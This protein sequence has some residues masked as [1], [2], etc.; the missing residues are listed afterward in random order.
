MLDLWLRAHLG[1]HTSRLRSAAKSFKLEPRCLVV[2]AHRNAGAKRISLTNSRSYSQDQK[3][4]IEGQLEPLFP[5]RYFYSRESRTMGRREDQ[6]IFVRDSCM[7]HLCVG[8]TTRQRNFQTSQIP[9]DI[10]IRRFTCEGQLIK[11]WW[12]NDIHGFPS[13]HVTTLSYR[14]LWKLQGARS[15]HKDLHR[16]K[17]WYSPDFTP[18][19]IDFQNYFNDELWFSLAVRHLYT[20]GI[21]FVNNVPKNDS[22]VRDIT[23]RIGPLRNTFYGE[24][25]DVTSQPNARNVAYTS[26][27]LDFHMDL[28][29]MSEPPSYQFLHCMDNSCPGGLSRFVDTFS[30]AYSLKLHH[31]MLYEK[32]LGSSLTFQYHNQGNHYMRQ[33]PTFEPNLTDTKSISPYRLAE[34]API[35]DPSYTSPAHLRHRRSSADNATDSYLQGY[36]ISDLRAVNYSPPFQGP[37]PASTT[38]LPDLVLA[39]SRFRAFLEFPEI[40]HKRKLNPG[41]CVIFD[42]RRIAHAREA[43]EVASGTE[44]RLRGAYLDDDDFLSRCEELWERDRGIWEGA[45]DFDEPS[46]EYMR[47]WSSFLLT[48]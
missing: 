7:C 35:A 30:A 48:Q 27:G 15:L 9:R 38:N 25:W 18:H 13:D 20:D 2:A 16:R 10:S 23:T 41:T 1:R 32:L 22:S 47:D 37:L 12:E 11:I 29:Y 46:E 45:V 5:R 34:V 31:P 8:I 42:N 36:Y 33:V 6:L 28:L 14:D 43:F 17:S 21:L 4:S 24:T 19:E 3:S 40:G 44:R 26:D 39:L